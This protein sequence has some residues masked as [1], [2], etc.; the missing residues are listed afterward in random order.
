MTNTI[1]EMS[2][3]MKISFFGDAAL[4]K[5]KTLPTTLEAALQLLKEAPKMLEQSN[6]G[7]GVPVE[8][9]LTPLSAFADKAAAFSYRFAGTSFARVENEV[10]LLQQRIVELEDWSEKVRSA[11]EALPKCDV[12]GTSN[13]CNKAKAEYFNFL[14]KVNDALIEYRSDPEKA[15]KETFL[16]PLGALKDAGL[17]SAAI[18][19]FLEEQKTKLGGTVAWVNMLRAKGIT[20]LPQNTGLASRFAADTACKF[21]IL[22]ASL[23]NHNKSKDFDSVVT[24][25]VRLSELEKARGSGKSQFLIVDYDIHGEYVSNWKKEYSH[26]RGRI[27]KKKPPVPPFHSKM[28]PNGKAPEQPIIRAFMGGEDR[29]QEELKSHGNMIREPAGHPS[30]VENID[31]ADLKLLK[32]RCPNNMIGRGKERCNEHERAWFFE[33]CK[34]DVF[35]GVGEHVY[36]SK[37]SKSWALNKMSFHCDDPHHDLGEFVPWNE[38]TKRAMKLT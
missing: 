28:M 17:D 13:F 23:K 4:P 31:Q 29:S 15:A 36:C 32:T 22:Y 8:Y 26:F 10:D 3:K 27:S 5:D 37:C 14:K 7:K 25:F 9:V 38:S 35:L 33:G 16:V 34:H 2:K 6:G 20:W 11:Q 24:R 19:T 21:F 1:K 30:V 18:L 12:D